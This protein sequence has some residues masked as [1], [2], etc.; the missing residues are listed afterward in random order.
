M[1]LFNTLS[2]KKE[3]FVPRDSGVGIY[4]CGITPYDV[5]HLGHAFSYVFYDSLRRYLNYQGLQVSYAQNVTDVDDDI[6][7]RAGELGQ[8]VEEVVAVNVADFDRDMAALN[9]LPPTHYPRATEQI[10]HILDMVQA[11]LAKGYAY[12]KG[13]D[14]F[15]RT[16]HFPE[17]GQLSHRSGDALVSE[18]EPARLR[19]R[20]DDP[21]NFT[22]WQE[23][24]PGEPSWPSPWGAG[25]PGWHIECAVMS[26]TFLGIP[27]DIHGGGS[28]LIFPHHES[29]IAQVVAS[30]GQAPF[31]RY[32]VHNGM[33]RI[34]GDKM[35]K[36]LKNL[37]LVSDLLQ[38]YHPDTIRT[39]LLSAHYRG[40]PAYDEADLAAWEPRI[41]MWR[42]AATFGGSVGARHAVP[43]QTASYRDR[44]RAAL[45]DDMD[46]PLALRALDDLAGA[47]LAGDGDPVARATLRELA[48]VL[49]LRL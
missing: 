22:L 23:S 21:R 14:V 42:R 37:V 36:S 43:R 8:P 45:D 48:E 18:T 35:A 4:V 11:L 20:M 27:V 25:R 13:G 44:F 2:R 34:G 19:E 24:L 49:G 38:R 28:D 26:T 30:T 12:A 29:E 32:W 40:E 6:I 7:R 39:Y 5:T 16:E 10:D 17:F 31:V 41:D 46:T 9:V 15:F 1:Q 47:I 3:P 33:L